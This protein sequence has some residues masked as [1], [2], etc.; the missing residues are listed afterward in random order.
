M[1]QQTAVRKGDYKLVLNGQLVETEPAPAPVFLANLVAD[2]SESENL[3][4]KLPGLTA[5]LTAEATA[6]REAIE[7][8]WQAKFAHRY[9]L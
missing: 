2:P 8:T 5:Q 1:G 9:K 6:W 3:A 7:Q 4:A